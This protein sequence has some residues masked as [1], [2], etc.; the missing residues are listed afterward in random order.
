MVTMKDFC[1]IAIPPF[2]DF[3]PRAHTRFHPPTHTQTHTLTHTHTHRN[4]P[5]RSLRCLLP[6]VRVIGGK[7]KLGGKLCCWV[8]AATTVSESWTIA[9]TAIFLTL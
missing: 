3:L 6:F 9:M 7:E 1:S 8:L 2:F 5:Y 4:I